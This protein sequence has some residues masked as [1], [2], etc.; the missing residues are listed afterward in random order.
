[1]RLKGPAIFEKRED[2]QQELQEAHTTGDEEVSSWAYYWSTR[3][4]LLG[5]SQSSA[6]AKCKK[7]LRTA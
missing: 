1:L 5:I 4:E 7:E 6:T 2:I 3:C